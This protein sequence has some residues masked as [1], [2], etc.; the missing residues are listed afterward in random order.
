MTYLGRVSDEMVEG[1]GR[2]GFGVG[3]DEMGSSFKINQGMFDN[4]YIRHI[5]H[6]IFLPPYREAWHAET[7]LC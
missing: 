4:V 6:I 2:K 3:G 7:K 5:M 1:K